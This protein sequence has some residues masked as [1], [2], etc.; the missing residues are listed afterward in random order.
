MRM[1]VRGTLRFVA[2]SIG[3][4]D[5]FGASLVDSSLSHAARALPWSLSRLLVITGYRLQSAKIGFV[6]HARVWLGVFQISHAHML[7]VM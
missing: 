4:S 3:V 1:Y 2:L 7:H 5:S 6:I